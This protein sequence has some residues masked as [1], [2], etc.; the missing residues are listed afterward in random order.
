[1]PAELKVSE[2]ARDCAGEGGEHPQAGGAESEARDGEGE[3][4]PVL[5]DADGGD[6]RC[7]GGEGWGGGEGG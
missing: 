5:P 3:G 6:G 4:D 2:G 1:M 7:A